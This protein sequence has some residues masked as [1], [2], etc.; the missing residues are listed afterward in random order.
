MGVKKRLR[1][2]LLAPGMWKANQFMIH[3]SA[4]GTGGGK[5]KCALARSSIL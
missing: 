3:A 1:R 5:K 4:R 2:D